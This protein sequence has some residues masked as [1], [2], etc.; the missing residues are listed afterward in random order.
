MIAS[1]IIK[2]KRNGLELSAEEINAFVL[3]Y[4]IGKIPDYQMSALLMAIYFKGMVSQETLALTKTM[5]HSGTTVNTAQI[6]GFQTPICHAVKR[7][8][9]SRVRR[10]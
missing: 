4:T 9:A 7:S 3:D 5:L 6:T 8:S 2:K 1:E 10:E